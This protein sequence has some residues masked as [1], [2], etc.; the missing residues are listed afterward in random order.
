MTKLGQFRC[1]TLNVLNAKHSLFT[2]YYPRVT[3]LPVLSIG[4]STRLRSGGYSVE[5]WRVYL[6][7]KTSPERLLFWASDITPVGAVLRQPA[8]SNLI[9]STAL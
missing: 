3:S 9:E 8:T 5:S 7:F 2:T 6:T 4:P 1:Q